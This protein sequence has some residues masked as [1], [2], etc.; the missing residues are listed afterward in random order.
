MKIIT[1]STNNKGYTLVELIIYFALVSLL[2]IQLTSLFITVLDAKKN[3][4]ALSEVERGGQFIYAR[5][6]YDITRAD[7]ITEPASLGATSNRIRLNIGGVEYK[8]EIINN[9]LTLT[10]NGEDTPLHVKTL[11]SDLSATR[12]GYVGDKQSLKLQFRLTSSIQENRGQ[13]SQLY[14]TTVGIR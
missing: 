6:V 10:I 13:E 14:Q 3:I 9:V 2:F 8:Y 5:L 4:H 7:S 12:L 11:A 1:I